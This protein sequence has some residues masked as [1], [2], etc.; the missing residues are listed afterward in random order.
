[1][2]RTIFV[3]AAAILD[4]PSLC[5][6]GGWLS[7]HTLA[8]GPKRVLWPMSPRHVFHWLDTNHDGFLTLSEFLAAPW[9]TD[10]AQATAFFQWLDTNHDGRLSLQE[11][12][13]GYAIY[14]GNRG[15]L[16]RV[17]YPWAWSCWQPWN[18]GW[19]WHTGWHRRPG[20]WPA[21]TVHVVPHAHHPYH[22]VVRHVAH[23]KH[24]HPAK[25]HHTARHHAKAKPKHHASHK[26]HGDKGHWGMPIRR[27]II[28]SRRLMPSWS[29]DPLNDIARFRE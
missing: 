3:L 20:S 22:A 19:Y 18:Y 5:G 28:N 21:Y 14:R 13:A 8:R 16:I 15:Y 26:G 29:Y 17:A 10:K 23:G 25:G 9:I 4:F 7:H 24:P 1:M 12:L 27:T 2:S 6:H 11:F